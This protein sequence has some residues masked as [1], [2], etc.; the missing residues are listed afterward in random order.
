VY[1]FTVWWGIS[2]TAASGLFATLNVPVFL[3]YSHRKVLNVSSWHVFRTCY[4]RITVAVGLV[5]VAAW[6]LLRPLAS[7]LLI[8]LGLTAVTG[9]ACL[10]ASAAIGAFTADDWASLKSVLRPGSSEEPV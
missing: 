4:A 1:S 2:G 5:L 10:L 9:L 6:V 7:S 8:T 3:H